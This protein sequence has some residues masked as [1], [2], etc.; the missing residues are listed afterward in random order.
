[1]ALTQQLPWEQSRTVW[2]QELNP[3]ITCALVPGVLLTNVK[4]GTAAT[5][6]KHGLNRQPQ[7]WILVD[8]QKQATVW[9]TVWDNNTITLLSSVDN[10]TI[11]LWVF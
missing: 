3:A 9:R 10:T 7:G 2:A 5:A 11:S 6:V 4:V 1:M 8:L